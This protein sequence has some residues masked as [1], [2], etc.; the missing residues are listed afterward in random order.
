MLGN[1]SRFT[2]AVAVW[3]EEGRE[4]GVWVRILGGLFL[5]AS[6]TS[7]TNSWLGYGLSQEWESEYKRIVWAYLVCC[8][9][10]SYVS[11]P[12]WFS[13]GKRA[14]VRVE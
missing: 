7:D 11:R 10:F 8:F 13:L 5:T 9:D 1:Q 14:V 6:L 2:A 12:E 4:S 3:R